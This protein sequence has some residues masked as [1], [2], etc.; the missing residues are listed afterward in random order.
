MRRLLAGCAIALAAVVAWGV[1]VAPRL[2]NEQYLDVAVPDLPAA[3]NGRRIAFVSDFQYGAWLAN[4]GTA[5]RMIARLVHD[6]PEAVLLGG[7]FLY[8][9]DPDPRRQVDDIMDLLAPLV[10]AEIPTYAVLGNHDV[11]SGAAPDLQ[12]ALDDAGVRVLHNEAVALRLAGG[13][14]PSTLYIVGIGPHRPGRDRPQ[15]AVADVPP[16][17]ARIVFMHHPASFPP[18]PAESAPLAIAGH[19]HCGQVRLPFTPRWSLVG[20]L[21]DL[22]VPM[23][24]WASGYGRRGNRLYVSCG[25]GFSRVPIRLGA[26]PQL[27][28][29]TLHQDSGE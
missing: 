22:D 12:G 9:A 13:R 2:V 10:D 19:T 4:K 16:K 1:V 5:R 18:L 27:T 25:V 17:A 15:A 14:T 26:R 6:P 7:D 8:S 20:W 29:F 24:G 3:W 21:E 23:D 11:A 28:V